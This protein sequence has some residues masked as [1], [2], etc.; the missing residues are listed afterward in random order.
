MAASVVGWILGL[1]KGFSGT[2][3]WIG[4]YVS[5]EPKPLLLFLADLVVF[6]LVGAYFGTGIFRPADFLQAMAAGLTWP[7]SLGALATKN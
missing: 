3:D 2:R 1:V 5:S 7:I 4:K 6:V